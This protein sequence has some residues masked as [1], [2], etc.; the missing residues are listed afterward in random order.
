M[1]PWICRLF[2]T[3]VRRQQERVRRDVGRWMKTAWTLGVC[4]GQLAT[5]F[6]LCC[7]KVERPEPCV[8]V[9]KSGVECLRV[10]VG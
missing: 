1:R 2:T 3:L 6:K 7:V 10:V 4:E 8:E 9:W 5:A